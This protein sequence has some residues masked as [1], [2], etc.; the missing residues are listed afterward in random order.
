M[1]DKIHNVEENQTVDQ[2]MK[3]PDYVL[4]EEKYKCKNCKW[5]KWNSRYAYSFPYTLVRDFMCDGNPQKRTECTKRCWLFADLFS[6]ITAAIIVIAFFV[7][8][9]HTQEVLLSLAYTI[10]FG[11]AMDIVCYSIER[12][13]DK[14]FE[15]IEKSRKKKYD[16]KIENLKAIN[17]AKLEEAERQ[18]EKEEDTYKDINAARLLFI[19]LSKEYSFIKMKMEQ[20]SD[21]P[22]KFPELKEELCNKYNEFLENTYSLLELITLDNFYF[23]EI[24]VLF[25]I[26]LPKLKEYITLYLESVEDDKETDSQIEELTKLFE[27]VSIRIMQ[28]EKNLKDSDS[29][30]LVHKMQALREV[31]SS[32]N[33]KEEQK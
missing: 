24:K 27:S 17:Q 6:L 25:Q 3:V 14:L 4:L 12:G 2:E 18:K 8:Y 26:H 32:T 28:I 15:S 29:E 21:K 11:V 13:V 22:V 1:E 23:S 10:I 9:A 33:Y 7:I 30:S 31:V 5:N 20:K 19:N 16:K